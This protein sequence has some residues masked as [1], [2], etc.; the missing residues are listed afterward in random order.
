MSKKLLYFCMVASLIAGNGYANAGLSGADT[1]PVYTSDPMGTGRVSRDYRPGE[2]IVKLRS[3]SSASLRKEK[4][5]N[6]VVGSDALDK[7]FAKYGV[8]ESSALM[9]Q[10]GATV[11]RK[12][13]APITVR[14]LLMTICRSCTA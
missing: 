13:P 1:D 2:V 6:R 7:V 4:G 14:L 9:P 3:E 5:K 11:S 8:S 12:R 10:S